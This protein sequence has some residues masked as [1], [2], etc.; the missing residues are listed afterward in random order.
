MYDYWK[1][2][3]ANFQPPLL[4]SLLEKYYMCVNIIV[5]FLLLD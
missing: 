5:L 4:K 3:E 2:L 1:V